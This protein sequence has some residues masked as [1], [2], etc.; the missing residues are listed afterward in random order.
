MRPSFAQ[1][2]EGRGDVLVVGVGAT[3]DAVEERSRGGVAHRLDDEGGALAFAEVTRARLS[4]R[5]RVSE[6]AEE[7]VAKLKCDAERLGEPDEGRHLV[8]RLPQRGARR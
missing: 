5:G 8:L 1:H 6:D 2:G 3:Q 7:V 4:R